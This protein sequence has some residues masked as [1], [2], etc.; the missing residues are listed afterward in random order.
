MSSKL[1]SSNEVEEILSSLNVL[2]QSYGLEAHQ[3]LIGWYNDKVQNYFKISSYDSST[4]AFSIVSTPSMFEKSFIP[5]IVSTEVEFNIRDPLDTCMKMILD[6]VKAHFVD[7]SLEIIHDFDLHISR[8]PK[9]LMQTAGHVS[10][11]ARFYQKQ[12]LG[13]NDPW[14]S[15]QKVFGVSIHP[16]FGGWFAFRAVIVVKNITCKELQYKEPE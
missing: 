13:E 8:R 6:K 9:V 10:G 1:L 16:E 4:L 11:A 5:F 7:L 3:F 12:D 14:N 15:N 2:L